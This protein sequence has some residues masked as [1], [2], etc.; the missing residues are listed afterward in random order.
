M[1]ITF[2]H[3]ETSS[4]YKIETE[5][6]FIL[7]YGK[8][9][10]GKTT[11]SRNEGFNKEFVFNDDFV[12]AN[13]YSVTED[14]AK[15]TSGNRKNFSK[16]WIGED[17]VE[18][19]KQV[20]ILTQLG[21]E[22]KTKF[23][24]I[25]T[26]LN[27]DLSNSSV[28]NDVNYDDFIDPNFKIDLSDIDGE[29]SRYD[30]S[31][32][33]ETS[34]NNDEELNRYVSSIKN[35]KLLEMLHEKIRGSDILSELFF[36]NNDNGTLKKL[37]TDIE[38]MN[39]IR[40][41]I[42][43]VENSLREKNIENDEMKKNVEAWLRIHKGRDSCVFCGNDNIVEALTEWEGILQSEAINAKSDLIV[44]LEK[45][46][47][48][49]DAI[50]SDQLKFKEVD[51]KAIN[52]V[53]AIKNQLLEAKKNVEKNFFNTFT[54]KLEEQSDKLKG[55]ND[56]I[57]SVKNFIINRHLKSLTFFRSNDEL[58]NDKKTNAK[59]ELN[60][61][62]KANGESYSNG[63]NDTLSKL[64]LQKSIE[65]LVNS[66]TVPSTY[67]FKV[68]ENSDFKTLSD[69]QKHKLALAMFL[70]SLQKKELKDQV[71]VIDDPVV[72]LDILSY[73]QLKT[74]L[75][76]DLIFTFGANDNIK[77]IILTHDINYLYI[78]LSNIFD[79]EHM[80]SLTEVYRLGTDTLE[81][82]SLDILKTDDITLFKTLISEMK[83]LNAFR[84]LPC[85]VLKIFRNMIDLRL[86]FKGISD[87][88]K[89]GINL[90]ELP[91][92]ERDELQTFSN[93]L[94]KNFK[95]N[96]NHKDED[97][98]EVMVK[99]KRSSEILGFGELLSDADI[100]KMKDIVNS[101]NESDTL[102][103]PCFDILTQ[104]D[105]FFKNSKDQELKEYIR[106]PRNTF[107]KNMVTLCLNNDIE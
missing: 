44:L 18:K 57:T 86:R 10:S 35:D 37:N 67:E 14:G 45:Y 74:Y 88:S 48:D 80:R 38:K 2:K 7:V 59:K 3:P 107:T 43:E 53:H 66:S 87:T 25:K 90:L 42:A 27:M 54:I 97:I 46:I 101:K 56:I 95:E 65:F 51:P 39:S 98:L 72:S 68:V 47:K 89:V 60:E 31:D 69:G 17:I 105:D 64:G 12:N 22:N 9:G 62:M 40:D 8:N 36:S 83:G 63:I 106:H 70:Y 61:L 76:K 103:H 5:K 26:L 96:K 23:D 52:N 55:I 78:Q 81:P 99:L 75:I 50:L 28:V 33:K 79:N 82:I 91:D 20:D 92:P 49:C 19:S 41:Q 29:F 32:K 93:Y 102:E 13:I 16:I 73:H 94:S 21:K 104:V 15:L 1:E 58:I 6:S 4:Q 85:I 11:L 84:L 30:L 77:L 71:I 34:I 100:D 24:E